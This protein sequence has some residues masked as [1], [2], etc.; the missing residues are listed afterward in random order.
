MRVRT[1]AAVLFGAIVVVVIAA[2][3]ASSNADG[4]SMRTVNYGPLPEQRADIYELAAP[5]TPPTAPKPI[6]LLIHGGGWVA[7]SRSEFGDFARWLARQGM[8]PVS[9]DYRFVTQAVWPAQ[10]DDV[11]Q[12]MWWL[13]ENA[14]SLHADPKR[15]IALGGSA[16]GHLA[17]W[18]GTTNHVNAHGTPSRAN[19]VVSM[20]GPW[21]LTAPNVRQDGKNMIAALMGPQAP[22]VASPLF[23]IDAQSAPTMMIHGTK[24]DLVPPDQSTR[25]CEALRA[26]QVECDL[27][28]LEGEGHGLTSKDAD[29][30]PMVTR[31]KAFLDRHL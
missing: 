1:L 25:A 23:R 14:A 15:V 26:V 3:A 13:R 2:R 16:G 10:A 11:E 12:A 19:L 22:R 29:P 18:L 20:W 28:L 17:A 7:G 4:V 9:I 5:P 27:M 30:M 21:D 24:D 31:L 6:I 8:V